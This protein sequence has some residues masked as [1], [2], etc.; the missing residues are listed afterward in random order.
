MTHSDL[1][2]DWPAVGLRGPLAGMNILDLSQQLPG[3]YATVLLAGLGATVIKV[4]PPHG[5]AARHLD[6]TMFANVNAGKSSI[7]L[8]LKNVDDRKAFYAGVEDAHI[9]V[10]GFRPG[11][12]GRLGVDYDTLRAINPDLL[13]CSISAYGQNGPLAS[14][15]AHDISLQALAGAIAPTGGLDRIGVPWVDLATGTTA[16]LAIVSAWHAGGGGYLDMSMLDAA[17]AW[18][19]IKPEAIR[20]VEPT[21][22]TVSTSDGAV[23]IALLEDAMWM[24]LCRG[25]GWTDWENDPGLAE[26]AQRRLAAQRIRVRLEER[27]GSLSTA[28]ISAIAEQYDLPIH[29][30]GA[31][32]DADVQIRSRFNTSE[33][34]RHASIPIPVPWQQPLRPSPELNDL[35]S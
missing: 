35:G 17:L 27:F 5:D 26:Y 3:P 12:V 28:E 8:D 14:H 24:R 34:A 4:E 9:V 20:A 30:F 1:T 25:L 7:A 11:V 6:A 2:I 32:A 21:Y 16:A 33:G 10:E 19:S 23:V 31:S 29:P 15:P 22:G 13:Y 18:S